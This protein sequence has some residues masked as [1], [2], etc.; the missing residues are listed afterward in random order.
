MKYDRA[1]FEPLLAAY[2]DPLVETATPSMLQWFEILCMWN[3]RIDLTAARD[4][5]ELTDLMVA[6][7]AQLASRIPH[8]ASV[9]DVGTG[10][11]APGF[12]LAL[13]RPDLRVTLVEPLA[14]RVSFLRSALIAVA[15]ADV[16][17]LSMR[18]DAFQRRRSTFDW[19]ISRATL[20][21]LEWL[22]AAGE[23]C[24]V[25]GSIVL[26]TAREAAPVAPM[27]TLQGTHEYRWPNT[28]AERR[29]NVYAVSA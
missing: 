7:A 5:A 27:R 25:E 19:V 10:A 18:F 11:G 2:A 15:R 16:A 24:A 28:R 23:S 14:K 9:V 20:P 21:P 8:G 17:L 4:Y 26:F 12:A 13:L 1:Q 3:A 29:L 22:A 6:D